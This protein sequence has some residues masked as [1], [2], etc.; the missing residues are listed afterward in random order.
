MKRRF[1]RR[2]RNAFG[3][4]PRCFRMLR[5]FFRLP[6]CFRLLWHFFLLQR[7]FRL[8]WGFF[9]LQYTN[10]NIDAK[11][12]GGSFRLDRLR[13]SCFPFSSFLF[14]FHPDCSLVIFRKLPISASCAI[15][16]AGRISAASP[17]QRAFRCIFLLGFFPGRGLLRARDRMMVEAANF[18]NETEVY[19]KG[20]IG[21]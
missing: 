11:Y 20:K 12:N 8:L 7:R 19:Q 10:R 1:R 15:L 5:C 3:C 16:A 13:L 14:M 21:F 2:V 9:R 18:I 17:I 6:R 4:L